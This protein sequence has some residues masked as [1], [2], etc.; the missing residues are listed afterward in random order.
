MK[1][2]K[3]IDTVANTWGGVIIQPD[4]FYDCQNQAEAE[5]F[6]SSDLFISALASNI[7]KVYSDALLI[8]GSSNS[9]KFL[10]S[11]FQL[12][13]SGNIITRP[14]AF[15]SKT[16]D[17][18]GLFKRVHG[19]RIMTAIGVNTIEFV[20]PYNQCKITGVELI[21]ASSCD[22]ID[23]EVYDTPTGTISTIPNY[24][25]NQF[26]FAVNVAKDYYA[27]RSEFDS[28]LIKDMKIKVNID[29]QAVGYIGLNLIL[30]EVK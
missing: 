1:R 23:L 15:A 3:N 2:I 22:L 4:S 30:N 7:A 11:A 10:T 13:G 14:T 27:H 8:S 16:I 9:I 24:K 6:A 29:A 17:G 26:G 25:L 19:V 18:K 12:D 20:I 21:G 5:K 28:D